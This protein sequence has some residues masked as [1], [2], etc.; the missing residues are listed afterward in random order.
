MA[1]LTSAQQTYL[2][3]RLNL[4][5]DKR[6]KRVLAKLVEPAKVPS[7]K[8]EEQYRQI[9]SGKAKLKPRSVLT[10]YTDL[11]E[12]YI[13]PVHAAKV[14]Q[15]EKQERAYKEAKS[16]LILPLNKLRQKITDR[17][18]LADQE[19]AIRMLE[20]FEKGA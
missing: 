16:K 8:F 3:D 19:E 5:Y 14:K 4:I 10:H 12:A 9:V 2:A 1:K 11:N 18:M 6:V 17:I 20:A 7:M 13:Y 15:A